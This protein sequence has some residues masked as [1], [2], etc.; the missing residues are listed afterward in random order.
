[1]G[2]IMNKIEVKD[3][4]VNYELGRK[5]GYKPS[6]GMRH[7]QGRRDSG[8]TALTDISFT[9]PAGQFVSILG[10]SGCG[11][12]TLLSVLGGLRLPS[13]GSVSIDGAPVTGPG[14]NRGFVF[15]NY[16]LFPWMTARNNVAF[17]IRQAGGGL[18][19]AERLKRADRFLER[20]GLE[21]YGDLY[22]ARL[23]GGMRQRVAIAR[24]LAMDTDI[25]LM[26]EP[27][28][29][30]D[31]KNRSILQDLLLALWEGNGAEEDRVFPPGEGAPKRE[32]KTVIFVTHDIDEAILMSDRII[33]L[34]NSPGRI[35]RETAVPFP[36][37]RD[38]GALLLSAEYARLRS[39]LYTLFFDD[40]GKDI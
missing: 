7:G 10:S 19:R 2:Q 16:S 39:E 37:P 18:S 34:T 8:F 35:F 27:F 22:P 15:Q 29:A 32:R 23:S 30:V 24:L 4:R 14:L 21:Q 26:D 11:K 36:R 6:L 17:G 13:E 40:F 33:M 28:G 5:P 31:A 1:M 20:V 25:L 3:L 9:V 38:R 12:S